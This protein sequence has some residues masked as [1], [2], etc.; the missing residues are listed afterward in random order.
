MLH[1]SLLQPRLPNPC[2]PGGPR[3]G[4]MATSPLPQHGAKIWGGEGG[5]AGKIGGNFARSARRANVLSQISNGR[6]PP[7]SQASNAAMP[8]H[9]WYRRRAVPPIDWV[10]GPLDSFR[11][12]SDHP[13]CDAGFASGSRAYY[14]RPSPPTTAAAT[15]GHW[16]LCCTPPLPRTHAKPPPPPP[17]LAGSTTGAPHG[18]RT[19]AARGDAQIETGL[20]AQEL[21]DGRS[22]HLPT[23]GLPGVRRAPRPLQ[24][25]L[26]P[27][28]ALHR[29]GTHR[30]HNT[31]RQIS[32][33]L[34]GP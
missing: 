11:I 30:N 24:L 25:Q 22:Q 6:P 8:R 2:R 19:C 12:P 4:A 21:T 20:A 29:V 15:G 1:P 34:R 31:R 33:A 10:S 14:N 5:A 13:P 32:L 3:A 28:T 26:P 23:I 18:K 9:T 16:C 7:E 17:P 27:L